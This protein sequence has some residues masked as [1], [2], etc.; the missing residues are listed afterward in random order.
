MYEV[1]VIGA[2]VGVFWALGCLA[3]A[4]EGVAPSKVVSELFQFH[5]V[6]TRWGR[7]T[8]P[9]LFTV[10]RIVAFYGFWGF[11]GGYIIGGIVRFAVG[12]A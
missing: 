4:A 7:G 8:E 3:K 9:V 12:Q 2:S 10:V 5:S 11:V 1:G 6:T